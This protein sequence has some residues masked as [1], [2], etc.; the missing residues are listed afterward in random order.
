MSLFVISPYYWTI[1]AIAFG[2]VCAFLVISTVLFFYGFYN[3]MLRAYTYFVKKKLYPN[4][5]WNSPRKNKKGQ[6]LFDS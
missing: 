5:A 1:G 4:I 2:S 3:Y 6:Y